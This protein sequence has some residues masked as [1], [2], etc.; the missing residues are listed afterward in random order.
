M[1]AHLAMRAARLLLAQW[2]PWTQACA[3]LLALRAN[4]RGGRDGEVFEGELMY[5]VVD[6]Y[7]PPAGTRISEE[8]WPRPRI[9]YGIHTT[10]DE[11]RYGLKLR[12]QFDT[13]AGDLPRERVLVNGPSCDRPVRGCL[14][15]E[16]ERIWGASDCNDKQ[17]VCK[18]MTYIR[19]AYARLDTLDFD[20]LLGVNEDQYVAEHV[21]RKALKNLNSSQPIALSGFGC[22]RKW[23]FDPRSMNGTVP[24]PATYGEPPPGL[25]PFIDHHG[26]ICGGT[27][28][29]YSRE[30]VR[31]LVERDSWQELAAQRTQVDPAMTCLLADAGVEIRPLNWKIGMRCPPFGPY[32]NAALYHMALNAG[33]YEAEPVAHYM[34]QLH[35]GFKQ[36]GPNQSFPKPQ[37]EPPTANPWAAA[38]PNCPR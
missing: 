20:W 26:G 18:V 19:R 35:E 36:L 4:D 11:L 30:A 22:G 16:G 17:K 6:P 5:S 38:W 27:G 2:L 3:A 24:K 25:C 8:E 31:R 21:L 12:S 37:P 28:I 14:K 7:R 33:V 9:I 29:A 34:R 1:S 23:E 15:S 13:W 10:N 32:P